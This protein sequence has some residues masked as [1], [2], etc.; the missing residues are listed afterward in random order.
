MSS[1]I[2]Q[3]SRLALFMAFKQ[4]LQIKL[5]PGNTQELQQQGC[6]QNCAAAML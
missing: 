6:D 2:K 3:V 1:E 4:L 5:F